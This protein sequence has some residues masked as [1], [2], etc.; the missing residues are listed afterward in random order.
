MID[1]PDGA[2]HFTSGGGSD[3]AAHERNRSSPSDKVTFPVTPTKVGGVQ[4]K[5]FD[6]KF[7]M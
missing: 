1:S 7:Q 6:C 4:T 5:S 3:F 2:T